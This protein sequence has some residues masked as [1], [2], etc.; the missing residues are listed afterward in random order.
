[1]NNLNILNRPN[2]DLQ[3]CSILI[4]KQLNV[5]RGVKRKAEKSEQRD[6]NKVPRKIILVNV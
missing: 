4:L 2:I 3:P 1:M 5:E 6:A